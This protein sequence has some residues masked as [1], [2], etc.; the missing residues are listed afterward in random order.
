[1]TDEKLQSD[2]LFDQQLQLYGL[3]FGGLFIRYC[4][5]FLFSF[6][7][8]INQLKKGLPVRCLI[9]ITLIFTK[10]PQHIYLV[11]AIFCV[12]K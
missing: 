11:S 1:M 2:S 3:L 4:C 10:L 8:Y 6:I 7:I 5:M 12:F 9:H